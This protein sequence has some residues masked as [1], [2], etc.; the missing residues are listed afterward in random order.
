MGGTHDRRMHGHLL[1]G[2]ILPP[3]SV[4]DVVMSVEIGTD[5]LGWIDKA[6]ET[7]E[8]IVTTFTAA[9]ADIN[10]ARRPGTPAEGVVDNI[11]WALCQ[12]AS[13]TPA[14]S[15]RLVPVMYTRGRG[16][17]TESTGKEK[18]EVFLPRRGCP[19]DG[20]STWGISRQNGRG[21]GPCWR[22]R[23]RAIIGADSSARR[24][25]S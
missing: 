16:K 18:H 8:L 4:V 7:A 2:A 12:V 19:L 5:I 17:F 9:T 23:C 14:G 3:Q 6:A 22:S 20:S 11:R 24:I 15:L 1:V 21:N 13:R 10:F 25:T